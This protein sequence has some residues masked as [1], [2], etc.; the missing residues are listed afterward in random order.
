MSTPAAVS[1]ASP[2]SDPPV[3]TENALSGR[4]ASIANSARRIAD[5]GVAGAGLRTTV[6]PAASAAPTFQT[7]ITKG[8][9]QA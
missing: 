4:P 1:S 2:T 3:T 9:F 8:K 5:L 7:A 6:H